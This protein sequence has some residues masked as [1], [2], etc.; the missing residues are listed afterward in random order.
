[1]PPSIMI[2]DHGALQNRKIMHLVASVHPSVRLS[3]CPSSRLCRVQQRAKKSHYQSKVFV[4]VR[5]N[6]VDAVNGLLI[7]GGFFFWGGGEIMMIE[8]PSSKFI[9]T[10]LRQYHPKLSVLSL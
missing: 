6:H 9:L 5:N 1:M 3:V 2:I 4:C 7:V 10:I 8:Y